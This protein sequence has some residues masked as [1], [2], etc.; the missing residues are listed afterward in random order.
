M[1]LLMT[2]EAQRDEVVFGHAQIPMRRDVFA[3][4]RVGCDRSA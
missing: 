4:M 3:M 1:Y 2:F